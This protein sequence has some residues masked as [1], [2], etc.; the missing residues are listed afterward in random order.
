MHMVLNLTDEIRPLYHITPPE[1]K[2]TE[3]KYDILGEAKQVV[4][5]HK[6]QKAEFLEPERTRDLSLSTLLTK[7]P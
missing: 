5:E 7:F 2:M 6:P 4:A 3:S 1:F